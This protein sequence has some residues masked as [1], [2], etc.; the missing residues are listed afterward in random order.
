MNHNKTLLAV[1]TRRTFLQGAAAGTLIGLGG[2]PLSA[3]ADVPKRGGELRVALVGGSSADRLDAHT[4]VTNADLCRVTILY[5]A[6]VHVDHN[7]NVVFG[8][9]ESVEPSKDAMQWTV[10]LKPGLKFHNGKDVRA[11]DVKFTYQRIA[12]PAKPLAGASPLQMVDVDNIEILDVR[13]VR[14]PMKKAYSAFPDCTSAGVYFGIVPV[15]YDPAKPVGTGPFKFDSFTPGRESLF[16]RF[17]EYWGDSPHLDAVRVINFESDIAAFNALQGGQVDVF[18]GAPLS[19]TSQATADRGL[20]VLVGKPGMW[21]PFTMRVDTAPFDNVDVRTALRLL[22]DRQQMIDVSLSGY[23]QVGNDVFGLYD[24]CR[25]TSLVRERDIDQAK[26]L[27][28]KAG[29]ENLTV[30]LTTADI[31]AGTV[32]AAQV[33]SRQAQDAGVTVNVKQLPVGEFYGDQYLK[34]P[35]AQDFWM[36]APYLSQVARA[37][38]PDGVY[39]ET[40]F[41]DDKYNQLYTEAQAT[42]DEKL[43]CEIIGQMQEIDFTR[44]GFIIP[45]FNQVVDLMNEQVQGFQPGAAGYPLGNYGFQNAWMA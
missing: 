37:T 31:A 26:F 41:D 12:N 34:W 27:L 24:K 25:N 20:K 43:H 32:A 28:K 17:D 29:Q 45:S 3:R 6:L 39:N 38:L 14:F 11:E 2:I 9:A 7:A 21:T 13:T 23:G 15:D 1:P 42:V 30:E 19:L 40:H 10:R 18:A 35:F 22:V 5:D 33:F 8:L 4:S 36:Y 44:G 16:T